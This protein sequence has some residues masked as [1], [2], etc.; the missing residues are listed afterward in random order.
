LISAFLANS[1]SSCFP[2]A[3]AA[4]TKEFADKREWHQFHT[5]K[6]LSMAIA[7]ETRF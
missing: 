5:P 3:I 6:N 1:I 4:T 2:E 7:G